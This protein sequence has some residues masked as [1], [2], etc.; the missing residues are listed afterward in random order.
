[1]DVCLCH[2]LHTVA[3]DRPICT[4][5]WKAYDLGLRLLNSRT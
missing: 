4:N 2:R 3:N 5:D 1:M